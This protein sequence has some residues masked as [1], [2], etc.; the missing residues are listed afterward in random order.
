MTA[1]KRF[2]ATAEAGRYKMLPACRFSRLAGT[3]KRRSLLTA[4]CYCLL[5]RFEGVRYRM[6]WMR[7][8]NFKLFQARSVV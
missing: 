6:T 4:F 3:R 7:T 2:S 1:L 5:S 8:P